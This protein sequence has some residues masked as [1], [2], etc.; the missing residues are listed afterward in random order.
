MRKELTPEQKEARRI[1]QKEYQ[2]KNKA[3]I[4]EQK[5]EY[6]DKNKDKILEHKKEYRE[7][8]KEKIS[9]KKRQYHK[10]NKEK[11]KLSNK[12]W[13]D[14]NVEN[15]QI[16]N[17]EYREQNKD[18]INEWIKEYRKNSEK[19]KETKRLYENNKYKSDSLFKLKRVYSSLIRNS[20]KRKNI[21]KNLK[22]VDILGCSINEFK[23]HL[24]SKFEPWMN[25]EN[26]GLYNGELNYGWDI[27]HIIPISTATTE[28]SLLK[29][30]HFSNLQPLCSRVN[31]DIKIN[32]LI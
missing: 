12:K 4:L 22:S 8:N 21:D 6:Y 27:D 3:K 31:R 25:W 13:Y 18:K 23:K 28:E 20:H 32:R 26:Y 7:L 10:L 5:K 24:E 17:K 11:I 1:Y 9:E 30:N 15:K 2:L 29:L 19:Y 16:Y 14:N